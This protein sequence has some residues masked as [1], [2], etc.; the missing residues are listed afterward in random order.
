MLL[1][2]MIYRFERK[3]NTLF[4]NDDLVSNARGDKFYF[5]K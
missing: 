1:I 4:A 2:F 5:K 3:K